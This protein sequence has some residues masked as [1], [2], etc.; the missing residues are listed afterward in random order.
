[1]TANLLVLIRTPV[2]RDMSSE[3]E[4]ELVE[5]NNRIAAQREIHAPVS[6]TFRQRLG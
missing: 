6:R 4:R 1:M 2:G 5:L 3:R